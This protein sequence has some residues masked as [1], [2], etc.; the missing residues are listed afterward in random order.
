[1]ASPHSRCSWRCPCTK[2]ASSWL[3]ESDPQNVLTFRGVVEEDRARAQYYETQY[4]I[5]RS[6]ALARKTL[7]SLNLWRHPQFTGEGPQPFSF[8]GLVMD[9]YSTVRSA[10][11]FFE[12][13]DPS[14]P[15]RREQQGEAETAAQARVVDAFL[16]SLMVLPVRNSELIDLAFRSA[17]PELAARVANAHAKAYIDQNLE[18]KFLASKVASDWL[19]TKLA[20]QGKQVEASE[21]EL[22]RY[23]EQ[24]DSVSLDPRND[25]VA[26]KLIDLNAAVTRAKTERIS[27]ETLYNQLRAIGQNRQ[28]LDTFPA[29]QSNPFVQQ[30]KAQLADLERQQAQLSD[31]LAER[32]PDMIKLRVS[33]ESVHTKLDLEIAKVVQAIHNEYL[34]AR[35]QENSL[36]SAL[37]A[38]TQESQAQNRTAIKYEALQRVASSNRQIF[39]S[40]LQRAKE[41]G[42]SGELRASNVR[43]V[44]TADIPRTPVA[45]RKGRM[46]LLALLSGAVL[47]VALA[48]FAEYLDNRIKTPDEI[49]AWGLPCFGL[50][51]LANQPGSRRRKAD[52]SPLLNNGVSPHF[53]ESFR[54]IRTQL[55]FAT[56]RDRG[57][58]VVTSTGPHEGKSVVAANL[59]IALAQARRSVLLIDADMR[60]PRVHHLFGQPQSPGLS[61]LLDEEG[62]PVVTV[63]NSDVRF[64][65]LVTAGERRP[66]PAELLASPRFNELL[67]SACEHYE[68]VVIDTPPVMAVT[69]ACVV[70]H[71]ASSVLF[72]VG[73]EMTSRHTAAA[74]LEQLEA[75]DSKLVGAVL[76]MVKLDRNRFY[77]SHYYNRTYGK[78]YDRVVSA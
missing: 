69:D 74:A 42:I 36:V 68:W 16:G 52:R 37:E 76:N 64:L 31:R 57:S 73:A 35:D 43:I 24:T 65:S 2:P 29:I 59:A 58:I 3:I 47:A 32:H 61:N 33:I 46:L 62:E 53:T 13:P 67:R 30:L 71:I 28:A 72:V 70:A 27:R 20:E 4:T 21:N 48:F 14:P 55:L 9:A 38:Q 45:P 77:Y 1:M 10:A 6:R 40:L 18:L 11:S 78:Y 34:S 25:I 17:D 39:E 75:V 60:Q 5:L 50:I 26:Q 8:W 41:T 49:K 15:A 63:R 7:E 44:D 56:Q 23:R 66:N 22:Q 51:P 19:G 54:T 12:H